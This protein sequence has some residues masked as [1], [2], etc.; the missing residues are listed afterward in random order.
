MSIPRLSP[1]TCSYSTTSSQLRFAIDL[2]RHDIKSHT[3]LS[4]LRQFPCIP[5]KAY[6]SVIALSWLEQQEF[7]V[8]PN[9]LSCLLIPAPPYVRFFPAFSAI[10][11]LDSI[12]TVRLEANTRRD[13]ELLYIRIKWYKNLKG[14]PTE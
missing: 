9:L 1:S 6:T 10:D 11:L 5:F 7:C 3:T 8:E 2:I 14:V 13:F 12:E 4:K